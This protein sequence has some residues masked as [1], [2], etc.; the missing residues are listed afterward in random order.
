MIGIFGAGRNG[1]T[2]LMR[3]LDGSPGLW[4]Y[5]IELNYFTDFAENRRLSQVKRAVRNLLGRGDEKTEFLQWAK[6]QVEELNKVYVE[7]LAEPL[8]LRA[9]PLD[10]IAQKAG[11]SIRSRLPVFL[12]GM[13]SAYDAR[14]LQPAPLLVFKSIEVSDLA[15]YS[16][17]FPRMR[18]IHIIRHPFSNY[19]SLKRTNIINKQKPFWFLG[20]L[21]RTQLEERW[22][23]HARFISEAGQQGSERHFVTTYE[24]LCT[25]P[26]HI[27]R[28]I[29]RWLQVAPPAVPAVQTVLG[30]R[31]MRELPD[32][33]S[34]EG[35]KTPPHVVADMSREFGYEDVLTQREKDFIILR[36]YS[37][38]RRLGYFA[39]DEVAEL[40]RRFTVARRWFLPDQWEFMNAHSKFRL[41][42]AVLRRRW[43]IYSR[44]LSSPS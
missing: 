31:R 6:E 5:P 32:N 9:N 17:L 39:P 14:D 42:G 35:V 3:L 24:N 23:A 16:A 1:S 18:F 34:K 29:C 15:T 19:A 11:G 8:S 21:L 4:V 40:P 37:L 27:V 7:Q 30:G 20:D 38:A 33:P 10:V 2:L 41:A 12:E 36:T 26:T 13:R 28:D 44:L 25:Q 22:L 43:Y